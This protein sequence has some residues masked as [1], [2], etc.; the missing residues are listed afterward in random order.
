[1]NDV[2]VEKEREKSFATLLRSRVEQSFITNSRVQEISYGPS[3][4]VRV[5]P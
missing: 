1:M 2:Q 3:K 5:Y 4:I